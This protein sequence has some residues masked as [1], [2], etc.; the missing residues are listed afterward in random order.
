M[1]KQDLISKIVEDSVKEPTTP[2]R[3]EEAAKR[4]QFV[5]EQ[6]PDDEPDE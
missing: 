3:L 4:V 5:R 2:A 1:K 6:L